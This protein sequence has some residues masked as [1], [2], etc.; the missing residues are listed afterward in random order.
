VADPGRDLLVVLEAPKRDVK[1]AAA[2]LLVVAL[3][4]C[5]S[6]ARLV[7]EAKL[8][9]LVLQ[10][11]DLPA[12][13]RQ[14]DGGRQVRIDAVG[15]PRQETDRFG[16]QGGW[17]ARYH[18]AGAGAATRGALV[19][20]SRADVFASADGAAHDLDAYRAQYAAV[21]GSR[22]LASPELGDEAVATTQL[23]VGGIRH[24]T[25]AWRDRNVT[26]S[27]AV[28]GFDGRLTVAD[29]LAYAR[30]QERRISAS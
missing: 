2:G 16:R 21:P 23:Q 25:V 15:G 14:F 29:A 13:F 6:S 5:G 7:P 3:A 9:S 17:K 22:S 30:R 10:P 1:L 24:Y 19:V 20:E 26:A 4:G 8:S 27:I 12:S 18:R 28:N 11:A